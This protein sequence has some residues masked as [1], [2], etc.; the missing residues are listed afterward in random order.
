LGFGRF[1]QE[2]I[3]S[4]QVYSQGAF[5]RIR[6][7]KYEAFLAHGLEAR[8]QCAAWQFRPNWVKCW[9]SMIVTWQSS[10]GATAR[11]LARGNFS[12]DA[13]GLVN[14]L[15]ALAVATLCLAGLL[16]WQGYWPVLAVA[17]IQLVLVSWI[18]FRAWERAWVSEAIDI[19]PDRIEVTRQRHKRKRHFELATAWAAIE[20][21]QPDIAWYGPRIYLRSGPVSV[22]LGVFLTSEEK[23]QLAEKLQS[24]IKKHSAMKGALNF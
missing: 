10:D 22:E 2:G 18:L 3:E 21:V 17:V 19:G 12:L 24:A 14:L 23:H 7:E 11:I 9:N 4:V 1:F 5:N 6:R 20:M 16:A 8:I 13:G 15:L